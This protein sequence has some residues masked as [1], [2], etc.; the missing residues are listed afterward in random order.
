MRGNPQA[1]SA[2][3]LAVVPRPRWS[4]RLEQAREGRIRARQ[5]RLEVIARLNEQARRA[6]RSGEYVSD[7]WPYR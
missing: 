6:R 2:R 5:E 3:L 7:L 4:A 1:A